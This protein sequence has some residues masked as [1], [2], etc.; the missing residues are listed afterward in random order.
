MTRVEDAPAPTQPTQPVVIITDEDMTAFRKEKPTLPKDSSAYVSPFSDEST[1]GYPTDKYPKC[2][3]V[4]EIKEVVDILHTAKIPCSLV[5]ESAL[6]YYGAGRIMHL[7]TFATQDWHIC[8]PT[9]QLE[10]AADLFRVRAKSFEL[11]SRSTLS[12]TGRIDHLYPRFKLVGLRLFF[13]LMSS[14]ACHLDLKPE[15][16]EFSATGLPYPTLAVFAQSLLDGKV[17][18]DLDDLVDGMNLTPEW[19]EEHLDLEG[20]VDAD[21]IWWK[22]NVAYNLSNKEDERPLWYSNPDNRRDI[23]MR[24]VTP[25]AKKMRQTWKYQPDYETRFRKIGCKDP[26]LRDRNYC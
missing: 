26:R 15:N 14:Q 16:I 13:I 19:G 3:G 24:K 18:V 4:R 12:Y 2:N 17:G 11:V 6:I 22:Y 9:E 23:W 1:Q 8:V 10:K 20:T 25:E 7:T 5:G 21:W